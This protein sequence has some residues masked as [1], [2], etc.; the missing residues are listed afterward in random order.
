MSELDAMMFRGMRV[1]ESPYL[2]QDGEPVTVRRTWR[3]RL[4]SRP[5]RPLVA[6]RTVVPRVP[7]RGAMR[8][9]ARTLV[10]HPQM[11]RE[12]RKSGIEG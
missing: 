5:W 6:T 12:L 2:E 7:Y 9:D 4:F 1:I 8:L 3:E 10:M 11:L